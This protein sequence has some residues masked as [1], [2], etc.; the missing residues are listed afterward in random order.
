MDVQS[1]SHVYPWIGIHV[2]RYI[3]VLP[4]NADS[5]SQNVDKKLCAPKVYDEDEICTMDD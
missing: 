2:F 3:I 5:Q 1:L 4:L